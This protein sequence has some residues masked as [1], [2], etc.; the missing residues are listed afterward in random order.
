VNDPPVKCPPDLLLEQH[1]AGELPPGS[2]HAE[3]VRTCERC[4]ARLDAMRVE[5]AAYM[6]SE[7]AGALR[8]ELARRE[9]RQAR[10]RRSAWWFS[11]AAPLAAAVVWA[12]VM[13]TKPPHERDLVPMGSGTVELLVGHGGDVAPWTGGPLVPG[14]V[15][16]LAW[17]SIKPGYV[18][19][20]G[21]EDTG[22]ME[23][24]FPPGDS[25][26]RLEPGMRPFGDSLRFDPPFRGA[27]YV[28]M[29][30]HAFLAAPEEAAIREGREPSFSGETV[31]L[32]V[33]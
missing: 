32:R 27:V 17:T 18:L 8:R 6:H 7:A 14:D 15:I 19:V 1:L 22:A 21:R 30:D 29:A 5:G 11:A 25:A 9:T 4:V 23:R 33:P 10:R 24:W 16:Q 12:L 28:F 31:K 13:R 2:R 20:I 26:G 3:H